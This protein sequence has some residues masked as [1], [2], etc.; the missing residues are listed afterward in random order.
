MAR[1]N[2]GRDRG[3]KLIQPTTSKHFAWSKVHLALYAP[4]WAPSRSKRELG[5]MI[6]V[7]D[8]RTRCAHHCKP[9]F[10]DPDNA[11]CSQCSQKLQ[12]KPGTLT[13]VGVRP[14]P[15]WRWVK[16]FLAKTSPDPKKRT[17]HGVV[18]AEAQTHLTE[19]L[20]ERVTTKTFIRL[21]LGVGGRHV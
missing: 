15:R 17:R 14:Q 18:L 2:P 19:G 11:W 13:I 21:K 8:P 3:S 4:W 5:F 7:M 6:R 20:V 10:I 16:V 12:V 1:L 9:A